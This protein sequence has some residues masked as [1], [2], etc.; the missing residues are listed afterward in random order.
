ME[1]EIKKVKKNEKKYQAPHGLILRSRAQNNLPLYFIGAET[2]SQGVKKSQIP[3][4]ILATK[5]QRHKET[6]RGFNFK[7]KKIINFVP[8]SAF[9]PLWQRKS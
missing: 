1:K 6:Q 9:V 3:H 8:L 2:K 5:A 4:L 7:D